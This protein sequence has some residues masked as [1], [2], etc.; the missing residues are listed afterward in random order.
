MK[1]TDIEMTPFLKN[2]LAFDLGHMNED[3]FNNKILDIEYTDGLKCDIYYPDI[4]KDSYPVFLIIYGGGWVSGFKRDK[5]VEDMLIPLQYGYACMTFDYTLAIDEQFPRAII[6]CKKAIDFIHKN[7][8]QY[9]LDDTN[10]TVWGESAGAHLGLECCLVPNEKFDLDINTTVKNMVIF[11]PPVN[12]LTI[13]DYPG[14]M[15]KN[16]SKDSVFGIF[17]GS[18]LEDVDSLKLAS[19]INFIHP[20][21]PALWLQH[22]SS[23]D[24]VPY[25]QSVELIE[26][27][28]K[29]CPDVK[30]FGE[31]KEG[32]RHTDPY[33]FSKENF[34]RIIK[35]IEE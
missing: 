21:M 25:Q 10:I 28:N 22:G 18:H 6:D 32:K 33:F 9:Q 23:D 35:F 13:D 1:R 2:F 30:L 15:G 5:F 24:L 14:S 17:M 27:I 12:V 3:R 20:D 31:I 8:S 4:K 7:A 26:A 16:L 34:E 19:P 29:Q 11:Y